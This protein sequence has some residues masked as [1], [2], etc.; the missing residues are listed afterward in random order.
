M[1]CIYRWNARFSNYYSLLLENNPEKNKK[2]ESVT[3]G[4]CQFLL[5]T[6]H[7]TKKNNKID[8]PWIVDGSQ[9]RG[10][11]IRKRSFIN[12]GMTKSQPTIVIPVATFKLCFSNDV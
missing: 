10:T 4:W 11:L 1:A 5:I 3:G 9:A 8:K 12:R 6:I 7:N 2:D